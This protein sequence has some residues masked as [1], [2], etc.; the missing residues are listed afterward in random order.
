MIDQPKVLA[1][2][3]D[4]GLLDQ[5]NPAYFKP[6]TG[7]V[8]SDIFLIDNGSRKYVIKQARRELKVADQWKAD[9]SRNLAER[10]FIEF[11]GKSLPQSV[12]NIC[13][14]DPEDPYFIMEFLA[15]PLENWKEK[16]L[17]SRY[18]AE[19]VTRASSLLARIHNLG[20]QDPSVP[21]T[22][23]FRTNFYELRIEPYLVTTA[24]RHKR[25]EDIY[26][27]E[28]GRLESWGET[29]VHGDF[30]PKNILLSPD[31][32]VIL[33]HEVANFGDPAFDLAFLLNHLLLKLIYHSAI[34][35]QLID[36]PMIAWTTYFN[37]VIADNQID[38]QQRS[39]RLLLML[40]LARVDGKSPVEYLNPTQQDFVRTWVYQY[41][42]NETSKNFPFY[43][44]NLL[45][46]IKKL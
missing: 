43:Y 26:M 37:N 16:L 14:C 21:E 6:L 1:K 38:L 25:L 5:Q 8:S 19:D 18:F 17:G 29:L 23:G 28:A 4:L 44:S 42:P 13:Y 7:G 41:L 10:R 34:A 11:I 40:M 46:T 31:R 3:D 2:L 33:D 9:V 27:T 32:V 12:P 35:E 39:S 24:R 45:A 20:R 15:P 36:L 30:S 22:F